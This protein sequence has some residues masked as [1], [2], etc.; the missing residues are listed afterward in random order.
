MVVDNVVLGPAIGGVRIVADAGAQ[1][2]SPDE[3]WR[4]CMD[5]LLADARRGRL[6]AGI[7]AALDA[8]GAI[9]HASRTDV[10][11]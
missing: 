7:E 3:T 6:A 11:S 8:L 5:A 2:L 1:G 10:L 4:P 9:R